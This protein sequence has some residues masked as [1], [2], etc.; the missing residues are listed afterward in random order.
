MMHSW[1]VYQGT[2]IQRPMNGGV[3][4]SGSSKPHSSFVDVLAALSP[5]GCCYA[6]GLFLMHE[7]NAYIVYSL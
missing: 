5:D 6:Q 4:D 1:Y 7:I 3:V 2:G